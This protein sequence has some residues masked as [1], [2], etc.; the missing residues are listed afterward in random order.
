MESSIGEA[1]IH[2]KLFWFSV[3]SLVNNSSIL[4][5]NIVLILSFILKVPYCVLHCIMQFYLSIQ[6]NRIYTQTHSHIFNKTTQLKTF[7]SLKL[8]H[9][10]VPAG[11]VYPLPSVW[12]TKCRLVGLMWLTTFPHKKN[13]HQIL[14][15]FQINM[16]QLRCNYEKF[17]EVY[18]S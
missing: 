1:Y 6:H 15:F 5:L 2:S 18:T 10:L 14:I 16:T 9:L 12:C 13:E 3:T 4:S 17:N 7:T 11:L 8:M